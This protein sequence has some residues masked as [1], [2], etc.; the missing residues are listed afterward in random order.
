MGN[1]SSWFFVCLFANVDYVAFLK[2]GIQACIFCD[3]IIISET[4]TY[5]GPVIGWGTTVLHFG[6]PA[7]STLMEEDELECR[8]RNKD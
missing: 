6:G 2:L 4:V 3:L 1:C 5:A 7:E 8:P